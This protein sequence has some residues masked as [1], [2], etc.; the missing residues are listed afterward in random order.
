MGGDVAVPYAVE[1]GAKVR[2]QAGSSRQ[3]RGLQV[4]GD[5]LHIEEWDVR[6]RD[7][8]L[9][10]STGEA[11][12]VLVEHPRTLHYDLFDSHAP[13]EQTADHLR[14]EVSVP[15]G[16]ETELRVQ[17][18][19]LVSRREE[20]RRQ[21]YQGLQRYLQQGLIDHRTHAKV[22]ELLK[23]W[24]EIADNERA[25]KE[26]GEGRQKLYKVQEQ[27]QG[28]M[29]ALSTTGKEGTL[30]ARYVDQLEASEDQ[31]KELDQRESDLRVEIERL[32]QEIE[33][34]IKALE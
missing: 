3:V 16:G 29:G 25:L 34:R 6:W 10:N 28:N 32:K 26:A 8:Q 33:A 11:L 15:P 5:Y 13:K 24:E 21:S 18:R 30:R 14:F 1:L 22:A 12:V 2:E 9:N 20:L 7:Y 23:L 31:L 4:R 27:I 19:R 17:E